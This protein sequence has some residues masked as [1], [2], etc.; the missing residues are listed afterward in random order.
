MKI[1]NYEYEIEKIK[2]LLEDK[3]LRDIE[4]FNLNI[5]LKSLIKDGKKQ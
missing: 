1:K 5:Y 3:T 4:R 2:N